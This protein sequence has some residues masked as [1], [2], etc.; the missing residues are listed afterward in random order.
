M[1]FRSSDIMHNTLQNRLKL[2][3]KSLHEEAQ[4]TC[5]IERLLNSTLPESQYV[6][7]ISQ[8]SFVY[9]ALESKLNELEQYTELSLF[10]MQELRR[11]QLLAQDLHSFNYD[12]QS[13]VEVCDQYCQDINSITAATR[14][15]LIGHCYVRYFGDLNGGQIIKKVLLKK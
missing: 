15:R 12:N 9:Q 4:S 2:A 13:A 8:L 6:Q 10:Q 7:Y 1:L 3:T 14:F 11:H 5:F